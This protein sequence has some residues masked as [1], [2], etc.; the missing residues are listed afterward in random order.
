MEKIK[1][2]YAP[3]LTTDKNGKPRWMVKLED[4]RHITKARWM[5]MNYLCTNNI[6]KKI[7]IHHINGISD[8]DRIENFQL[9]SIN[10]HMKHHN[11]YDYTYGVSQTENRREYERIRRKIFPEIKIKANINAKKYYQKHKDDPIFQEKLKQ[12]RIVTYN[13]NKDNPEYKAKRKIYRDNFLIR[14]KNDMD[15]VK[16]H[17]EMKRQYHLTEMSKPGARAKEAERVKLY[18]LR[19]IAEKEMNTNLLEGVDNKPC[20]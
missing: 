1:L 17:K 8:D 10:D 18:R 13:K 3:F 5:M 11:P 14:H 20:N 15:W 16:K 4:G 6:P 9:I 12:K 2:K 19:K 7:H